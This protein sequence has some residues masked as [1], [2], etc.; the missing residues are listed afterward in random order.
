VIISGAP[1][2]F[3]QGVAEAQT[4]PAAV[5]RGYDLLERGWVN[6]AIAAFQAALRQSPNSLAARLGLAIAYQRAGQDANAWNAYQQVLD[7][8]PDNVAALA[9]VGLLGSYRPEWQ[10][11]GI[12][13]LTTLL[14]LDPDNTDARL[15]R[16]LL[17]RYQGRFAESIADYEIL[18]SDGADPEI[19]L[20]AAQSYAYSGAYQQSLTQFERYQEIARIPDGAIVAYALALRETGQTERAIEILESRLQQRSEINALTLELQSAL[21]IAYAANQQPEEA[22][23]T[24]APLQSRNDSRLTLARSLSEIARRTDNPDLYEDAV[25]LYQQVLAQTN[26][27][28]T[29][30]LREVAD[31]YRESSSAQADALRL[32]RQLLTQEP[33]DQS[34]LVKRL[35]LEYELGDMSRSMLISQLQEVGRSLPNNSAEQRAIALAL[36]PLDPPDPAVLPLYQR[37]LE[38]EID[39]PFLY[40]RIA[41]MY[42]QQSNYSAAR[43]ALADYEANA[44]ATP[45]YAAALLQADIERQAGNLDTSA[46]QYQALIATNPPRPILNNARRGL[47]GVQTTQGQLL[48]ALENYETLVAQ[49]PGELEFELGRA[50]IAYRLGQLTEAQAE[51]IL[52][53]W[54]ATQPTTDTPP[55]LYSL[56]GTLPASLEREALYQRLLN[57]DPNNIPVNLRL[58]QVLASQDADAAQARVEELIA[59][60]PDNINVYFVQGE[61]AQQLNDLE[62]ASAAYE[63]ILER[64][65][66]NPDA[67]SAL[68]GVRFQQDDYAEASRLYARVLELKP[69]DW[70]T[71]RVLAELNA[72]QGRPLAALQQMRQIQSEQE[73]QGIRDRALEARIDELQVNLLRRRGFQPSWERY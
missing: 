20:G 50:S 42:L 59:Q 18:L 38:A 17:L 56:V 46:S 68:G 72:V 6:D 66:D 36:I 24:L 63:A 16:A 26:N 48:A 65:P 43:Q 30:F 22:I 34:L 1:G 32:Y 21:A 71:R 53:D 64:N 19:L 49:N 44:Y 5:S 29:G 33:N 25:D 31:V 3:G 60:N 11:S 39:V 41:Q 23:A 15:Q 28:S 10:T 7:Q 51:G 62:Q 69:D 4:R 61:L 27:P 47:A 35:L 70:E 54:L 13:A 2:S 37:L 12:A 67:L 58:I 40:Y 14:Q 52:N 57:T 73:A 55:E 9:A 8:D 45:N